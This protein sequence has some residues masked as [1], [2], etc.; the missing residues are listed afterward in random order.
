MTYIVCEVNKVTGEISRVR[1]TFS[2]VER[3]VNRAIV[4]IQ[5]NGSHPDRY[6]EAYVELLRSLITSYID[7]NGE[8]WDK[9]FEAAVFARQV[10]SM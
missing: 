8:F 1:E 10:D 2:D 9:G 4:L 7:K 5:D 3:A 6:N